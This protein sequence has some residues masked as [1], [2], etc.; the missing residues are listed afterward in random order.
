MSTNKIFEC[1]KTSALKRCR[2]RLVR[3]LAYEIFVH[4][5][6]EDLPGDPC[7]DWFQAEEELEKLTTAPNHSLS[8]DPA[9]SFD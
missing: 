2:I 1:R 5:M 6:Q 4:R 8:L 7:S 9:P 3:Q